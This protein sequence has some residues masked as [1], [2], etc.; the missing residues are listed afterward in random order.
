MALSEEVTTL[1]KFIVQQR[2]APMVNTY[3]VHEVGTD[4]NSDGRVLAKVRQK[5][6][7]I[8]EQVNFTEGET[9]T[10]F[11]QI[12]ARKVFEFRG[13]SDVRLPDGTAIGSLQKVF[14]ASLLRS[15]WQILDAQGGIVATAE[16]SDMFIAI[17]RRVWG[18]IPVVGEVP[19]LLPFHFT[20]KVDGREVGKY[21]RI[22]S[23]RD[24]YV[25][26]L[27]GDTERRIDRRVAIAFAIALD[28]LQ[29][30]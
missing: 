21:R 1:D 2:F 7:K 9:D 8:R 22:W 18:W 23:W 17:L 12:K 13:R 16:E 10:P 19:F 3:T 24:R 5:R 11:L 30:R 15:T 27:T 25:M 20:I 29:D 26:D 4:D 6:M 28:A 14:G